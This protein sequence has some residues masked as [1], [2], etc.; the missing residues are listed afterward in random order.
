MK[1]NKLRKNEIHREKR[2][3]DRTNAK[4]KNIKKRRRERENERNT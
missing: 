1:G 2:G 3:N 4:H